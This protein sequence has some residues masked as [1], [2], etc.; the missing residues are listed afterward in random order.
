M[1]DEQKVVR[2]G[3]VEL[4]ESEAA[5]YAEKGMYLVTYSKIIKVIKN[6]DRYTGILIYSAPGM[7]KRGRYFVYTRAQ[8]EHFMPEALEKEKMAIELEKYT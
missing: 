8:V 6:G 1:K 7:T 2:I 4:L 3:S 5:D